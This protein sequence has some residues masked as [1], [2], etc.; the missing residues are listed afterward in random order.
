MKD[1]IVVITGSTRGFGYAIAQSMLRAGATVVISGRSG[2]AL[3]RAARSLNK[4]GPVVALGCDV[5]RE[6]QVY[7]MARNVV[8]RFGRIDVWINN[9]GYSAVAGMMI[10]I[11]PEEALDMFVANDLGTL[12]GTRAAL[13]FMMERKAGTLVNVYGAGSFLRPASPTGLYGATKAWITSFTRSLAK[14]VAGS[15]VH[16]VGFSPGML[17]TDMLQKPTVAGERGRQLMKNYAFVL[18]LLAGSPERA[19]DK[20]VTA[21][22]ANRR[23]FVEYR[24]FKPWTPLL[25]MIR[26]G[27]ENMTRTGNTPAF[28]LKFIPAYRPKI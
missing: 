1:K 21:V 7:A 24:L 18:R 3:K 12:H 15:G 13:H 2:P 5:R 19:A 11:R 28:R 6:R 22:Q 27:W 26:I 4:L 14:E 16:V 17:L 20:L 10:D 8:R 9:A 23:P 25:G